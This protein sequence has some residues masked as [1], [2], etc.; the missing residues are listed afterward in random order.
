MNNMQIIHPTAIVDKNA[1]IAENVKIGP[2]SVI[3]PNVQLASGVE[4][5][6]H[7]CVDGHT[8]IGENT[9]IYPFSVIGFPPP[10]LKYRGE[11]SR[12]IIGKNNVIREH[13]TMHTGTAVDR[14]QTDV[15][16]NCLFMAN[17]HVA[18]DCVIGNNVILA[19]C[20]ALGGHVI[21]ED[22]AI[23]GGLSAVQQRVR[24]GAHAIVGGMTGID[25]DLIPFGRAVGERAH[26]A[27]LN[28]IGLK[29]KN[30]SNAQIMAMNKAFKK[31]F[32]ENYDVF[33]KRM[34]DVLSEF[35]DDELIMRIIN[36]I[37]DE[38]ATSLC[39]AVMED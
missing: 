33:E 16:D 27:G 6:S 28:T 17:S 38:R 30:T 2:Y 14:N 36:F 13:V 37:K 11:D 7:V 18:H 20:A 4:I 29:R 9:K 10:D 5:M 23:I 35:G 15:G 34:E 22:Y 31:L 26:L 39:K 24:I 32:L 25:G 8:T 21:I 3:G 1:V 19:N 12:L